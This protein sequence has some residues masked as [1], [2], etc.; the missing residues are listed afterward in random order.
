MTRVHEGSQCDD[1]WMLSSLHGGQLR[2]HVEEKEGV[3]VKATDMRAQKT[4]S[5]PVFFFLSTFLSILSCQW[6]SKNHEN[7]LFV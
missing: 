1:T 7:F 2:E 3:A 5:F 6:T 4:F